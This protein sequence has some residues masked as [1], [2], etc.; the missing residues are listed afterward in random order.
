MVCSYNGILFNKNFKLIY[1]H[2][3]YLKISGKLSLDILAFN[4][5]YLGCWD[6]CG[7]SSS[8]ALA[9]NIYIK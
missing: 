1:K 5:S 2:T 3:I 6:K 9:L 8:A 4:S 7:A